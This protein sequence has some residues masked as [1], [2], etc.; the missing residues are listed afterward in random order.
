[1]AGDLAV[2]ERLRARTDALSLH[3]DPLQ[4]GG[5]ASRGDQH[6]A[7][8]KFGFS[9]FAADHDATWEINVAQAR[10]ARDPIA[11]EQKFNSF[12]E[13]AHDSL[14][15]AHHHGEVKLNL[16]QADAMFCEPLLRFV[17]QFSLLK[18]GLAGDAA[19]AETGA[20]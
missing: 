7:R 5:L 2:G 3:V 20:S 11:V 16:R 8:F 19:D 15:A 1:M 13:A 17:K 18:Q 14:L 12:S 9:L 6:V 10:I 4:A